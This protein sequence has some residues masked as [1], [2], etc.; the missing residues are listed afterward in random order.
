MLDFY[1]IHKLREWKK[2]NG[3]EESNIKAL[4]LSPKQIVKT[5]ITGMNLIPITDI[6]E[7]ERRH[8][9]FIS[10]LGWIKVKD[11]NVVEVPFFDFNK[12]NDWKEYIK[13]YGHY[14]LY[15]SLTGL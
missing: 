15:Y 11:K 9:A 12:E 8:M 10:G 4:K 6:C 14:C 3:F 2:P 1:Y 7:F 5:R 13:K